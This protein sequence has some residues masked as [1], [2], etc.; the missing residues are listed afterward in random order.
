M[1]AVV[2]AATQVLA[3]TP[4]LARFGS[5]PARALAA[6]PDL[7]ASF[8]GA[9]RGFDEAVAYPPHQAYLGALHPRDL[10]ERPW[11]RR[12]EAGASGR[13]A[14]SARFGPAGEVMPEEEFLGLLAAVDPF[15]LLTLDHCTAAAAAD[16]LARHPLA[17]WFD[18]DRLDQRRGDAG[19]A[20]ADPGALAI[21][22]P[23][24]QLRAAVRRAHDHDEALSAPVLL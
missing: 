17:K 2:V 18:L 3:H 5:K 20:A 4:G 12:A 19:A 8:A 16:A 23:G 24:G 10:P 13:P 22:G 7:A 21:T 1:S 9:L 11:V 14:A 6:R 15:G